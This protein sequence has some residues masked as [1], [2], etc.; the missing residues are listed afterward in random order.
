MELAQQQVTCNSQVIPCEDR[1]AAYTSFHA[2]ISA[3]TSFHRPAN[4]PCRGDQLSHQQ[5]L[6]LIAPCVRPLFQLHE[7]AVAIYR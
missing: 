7:I 5:I 2:N 4:R 6:P 3:S 1:G